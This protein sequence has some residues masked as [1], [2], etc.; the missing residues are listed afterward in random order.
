M[1]KTKKRIIIIGFAAVLLCILTGIQAFTISSLSKQG[2]QGEEVKQI[3]TA[4]KEQ[5]YYE[6]SVDGVFGGNTKKAVV[7]FQR[8][9]GLKAD[10]VA[11][12]ATLSALGVSGKGSSSGGS[13]SGGSTSGEFSDSEVA[14]LARIIS[15]ESR[16]EPYE[17]QVA[18]GAVILNRIDHPSFPNTI[19][20]VVYQPGAFTC[21]TDGQIN[22]PVE[23]SCNRAAQD[24]IGGWDPS[25]GA[26]YYFNPKTATSKWIWSR[27]TLLVIGNH[28]FCL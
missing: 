6:G 22:E 17:G 11:G 12:S 23:E 26:I 19:A 28:R 16:A 9:N 10:G 3:Q 18:V 8:D 24:A 5:G 7:S 25:G 14:L 1:K 2:S 21:V 27:E 4:L 13:N 20:G 15:A